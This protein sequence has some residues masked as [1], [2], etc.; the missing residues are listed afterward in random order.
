MRSARSILLGLTNRIRPNR[1]SWF[2][3]VRARLYCAF[4]FSAVL[5]L[6]GSFT[7]L[8]EFTTIGATTNEIL[9]HSYPATVVS[10]RLAEEIS[11]RVS[12]AP[13]LMTASDDKTRIEVVSGINRQKAKI[14]E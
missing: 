5:T 7:A 6:V 1:L 13:R 3:T 4:G 10:L 9:S 12:S 2:S 8:Y 11:S 14:E